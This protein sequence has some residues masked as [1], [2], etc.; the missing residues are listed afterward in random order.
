VQ[1][2]EGVSSV[3][4]AAIGVLED[5]CKSRHIAI[6]CPSEKGEALPCAVGAE[7]WGRDM[8]EAVQDVRMEV[9]A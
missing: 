2:Q 7:G 9:V 4:G 5:L 8:A 6:C 1:V 3:A